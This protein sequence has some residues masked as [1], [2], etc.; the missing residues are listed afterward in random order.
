[1]SRQ[2]GSVIKKGSGLEPAREKKTKKHQPS[3]RVAPEHPK[4]LELKFI[5]AAFALAATGAVSAIKAVE[6]MKLS[7][8]PA[9]LHTRHWVLTLISGVILNYFLNILC[10]P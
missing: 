5:H 4:K 6:P 2:I 9:N 10:N 1:M 8:I 3:L 7:L